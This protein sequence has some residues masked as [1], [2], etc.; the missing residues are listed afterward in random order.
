MLGAGLGAHLPRLLAEGEEEVRL[1]A[2]WAV[3]NLTNSSDDC[4]GAA[5]RVAALRDAGVS[6]VR[7]ARRRSFVKHGGACWDHCVPCTS[8]AKCDRM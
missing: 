7:C 6:A 1:A 2:L 4:P 8:S 5:K 3:I